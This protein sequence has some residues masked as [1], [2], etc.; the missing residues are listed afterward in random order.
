[1]RLQKTAA[2]QF[3]FCKSTS[4]FVFLKIAFLKGEG[5]K[6]VSKALTLFFPSPLLEHSP[7]FNGNKTP[8]L[9]FF[10]EEEFLHVIYLDVLG[11]LV[12]ECPEF[13]KRKRNILCLEISSL[14]SFIFFCGQ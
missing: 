12:I 5:G 6:K 1:M 7:Y 11:E 14:L 4:D 13:F 3:A 9:S 8:T 2:A 10:P